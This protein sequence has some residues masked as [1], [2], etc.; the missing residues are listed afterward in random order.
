[1]K[2]KNLHLNIDDV[3]LIQKHIEKDPEVVFVLK[4]DKILNSKHTI[5]KQYT[6]PINS[7]QQ[8][9]ESKTEKHRTDKGTGHSYL[10]FYEDVFKKYKDKPIKLLELGILNGFS[11]YLWDNYFT[12]KKTEIYGMDLKDNIY[13]ELQNSYSTRVKTLTGMNVYEEVEIPTEIKKKKWDVIIDDGSHHLEDQ[14]IFVEIYKKYLNTPGVIIIEDVQGENDLNQILTKFPD[15]KK[16]D[17]RHIKNR[18][19]DILC[20]Y[21]QEKLST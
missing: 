15:M 12:N 20:V 3:Q 10:N 6:E 16:I 9:L 4:I 8:L 19:D 18:Y 11:L 2:S 14:L 5:N 1:M 13:P 7:L 21:F 17:L